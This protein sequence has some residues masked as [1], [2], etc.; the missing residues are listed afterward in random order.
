MQVL[1]LCVLH[2]TVSS[3]KR[4]PI[5]MPQPHNIGSATM[6]AAILH[7]WQPHVVMSVPHLANKCDATAVSLQRS[8][9]IRRRST[10]P[11]TR[12]RATRCLLLIAWLGWSTQGIWCDLCFVSITLKRTMF[13][14]ITVWKCYARCGIGGS[15]YWCVLTLGS[16]TYVSEQVNS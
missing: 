10:R 9:S 5:K 4:R 16:I 12:M 8:M 2:S 7:R 1:C 13:N 15:F 3:H 14:A 11:I 6:M